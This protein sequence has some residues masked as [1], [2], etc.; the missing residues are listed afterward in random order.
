MLMAGKDPAYKTYVK[1]TA[2]FGAGY[3]GAAALIDPLTQQLG[4]GV[5][6]RI[7][8]SAIPALCLI[9]WI[10][11]MAR[12]LTDLQ[13]EF[14][15][16]LEVRKALIATGITLALAGGW[17]L[18]ELGEAVPRFPV[19]FIIPVWCVGLLIGEVYNRATGQGST[20]L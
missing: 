6:G 11:A 12:L 18:V 4:L 5:G 15:R 2:I 7:T 9:Y 20:P 1:R 10:W 8:L 19:F 14:L 17:G 16:M 13:D 3:I